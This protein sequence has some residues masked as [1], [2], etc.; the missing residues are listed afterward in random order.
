MTKSIIA[1]ILLLTVT[2]CGLDSKSKDT[3]SFDRYQIAISSDGK[4]YRLDKKSGETVIIENGVCK[5]IKEPEP[6]NLTINSLFMTEE[7]KIIQYTGKGAFKPSTPRQL[8]LD[9]DAI[10]AEITRRQGKDGET[11]PKR[12]PG[13]TIP[14][15]L[16]RTGQQ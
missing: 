1:L 16:K 10:D 8:T 9:L 12:L 15:Y 5:R 11:V 3:S 7:G 2:G 13:E 14:D 4:V 6:M